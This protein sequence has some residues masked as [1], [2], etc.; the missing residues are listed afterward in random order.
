METATETCGACGEAFPTLNEVFSHPCASLTPRPEFRPATNRGDNV[1]APDRTGAGTGRGSGK[2]D[3]VNRYPGRC[4]R[5]GHHVEAEK[6]VLVKDHAGNP[7]GRRTW[8]VE[9]RPGGCSS[10]AP[11]PSPAEDSDSRPTNRYPGKCV[12]CDVWVEAEQGVREKRNGRWIVSHR[13]DCPAAPEPA[14]PADETAELTPGFWVD[15]D[16][17][18]IAEVVESKAGRLYAKLLDP[19]DG[20]FDYEPGLIRELRAGGWEPLT[21]EAAAKLGR[22]FGRCMVCGRHLTNEV[23]VEAGIGPVCAGRLAA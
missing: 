5:C 7:G 15:P 11:P 6:G 17:E 23:S 20:R 10:E 4:V 2:P 18:H 12:R 8:G 21:V 19:D 14:E 1:D 13:G 9:H 3:P 22:R 16:T